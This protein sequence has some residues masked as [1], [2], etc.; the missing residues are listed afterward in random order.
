MGQTKT[1]LMTPNGHFL[2][3]ARCGGFCAR[4]FI[5]GLLAREIMVVCFRIAVYGNVA[6]FARIA[7]SAKS[8]AS[9][10]EV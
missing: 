7:S 4:G 2:Q 6:P 5:G 10:E 1:T 9:K 3:T 8:Q